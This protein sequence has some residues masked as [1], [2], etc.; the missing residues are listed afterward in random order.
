VDVHQRHQV[1][2]IAVVC[3]AGLFGSAG[4]ASQDKPVSRNVDECAGTTG[5]RG[6]M[7]PNE[8]LLRGGQV[9][10]GR[11]YFYIA[12]DHDVDSRQKQAFKAGMEMWN[13]YSAK[14]G[15]EFKDAAGNQQHD[16]RLQ[17][18]AP[19]H[20]GKRERDDRQKKHC[21][22]YELVGSYIWYS[23]RGMKAVLKKS[24]KTAASV[25]AH[26]LGHALNICHKPKEK[27]PLM[28][29]GDSN[30]DCDKVVADFPHDIPEG[31]VI[32]AFDCGQGMRAMARA[33]DEVLEFEVV[34]LLKHIMLLRLLPLLP[35]TQ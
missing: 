32:D 13:K 20:L 9:K 28:R 1:V 16:F 33:D 18:G 35:L 14:T 31:D 2:G 34:K 17:K 29:A 25:Y 10:D 22:A 15:F 6:G 23:P 26:E 3:L 19:R 8:S 11:V 4:A 12:Y 27:S 30:V 7:H 21:A 24:A 5:C